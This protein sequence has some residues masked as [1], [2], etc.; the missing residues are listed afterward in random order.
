MPRA[1]AKLAASWPLASKSESKY[2]VSK[3]VIEVGAGFMTESVTITTAHRQMSGPDCTTCK[4]HDVDP[5]MSLLR[6]DKVNYMN[7]LTPAG[8]KAKCGPVVEAHRAS[9]VKRLMRKV[10]D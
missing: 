10:D 8:W 1:R 3:E 5:G 2:W 9:I 4:E 7:E 6:I